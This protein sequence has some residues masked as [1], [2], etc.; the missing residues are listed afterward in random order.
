MSLWRQA[1]RGLRALTNRTATDHELAD[2]VR[3]YLE[4]ATA[5]HVARGLTPR[6]AKRAAQ[7]E[8]GS[9][10]ATREQVRSY[11]WENTIETLLADLRFATRRMRGNPGF[12]IIAVSTLALGIGATTAI[13]SAVYPILFAPLP[14]P[15]AERIAMVSDVGTNDSPID[16]TF[17]TF[18][19]LVARTHSF[20]EMAVFKPWQPTLVG[21]TEPERLNGQRV[22][23]GFFRALGVS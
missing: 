17:G 9:A 19:E 1:A 20:D 4:R 15:A 11:G 8:I 13:F 23:A 5:A 16:V 7:L 12:S 18:R 3:D 21:N 14:Y 10:T 2:E 6:D 22:S